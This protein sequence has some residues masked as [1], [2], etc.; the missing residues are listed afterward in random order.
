M[1][2]C[3]KKNKLPNIILIIWNGKVSSTICKCFVLFNCKLRSTAMIMYKK[4]N[5]LDV[6]WLKQRYTS[7][8]NPKSDKACV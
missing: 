6:G 3:Q 2:C 1:L 4:S 8:S 5:N 7:N